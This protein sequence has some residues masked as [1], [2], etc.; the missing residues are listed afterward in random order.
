MKQISKIKNIESYRV[1]IYLLIALSFI[2]I[3]WRTYQ[4]D[5]SFSSL[6]PEKGYKIDYFFLV[7]S[8]KED[9]FVK[10]YVPQSTGRQKIFNERFDSPYF[11]IKYKNNST[12]K[13]A[14]WRSK[15]TDNSRFIKYSFTF[16][17]K[18]ASYKISP[19]IE[20][21]LVY[22]DEIYKYLE[23]ERY[24]EVDNI[25]I[26]SLAEVLKDN[27]KSVYKILRKIHNYVYNI[28]S[29][30]IS[31]LTTALEAYEN[32]LASCNG[33]SRLF[34][35]LC[36][37][38]NIPA[39]LVG[40]IIIEPGKKRT[41][42]QWLEVFIE[43]S[44]VPFDALNN[45]FAYIPDYYMELYKGDEFLITHTPNIDFDYHF[46]ISNK[47][48]IPATFT[49]DIMNH[50]R[51]G[52]F[53]FLL[54]QQYGI[55]W[56]FIRILFLLPLAGIVVA[57]FKNVVGLKSF[58]IFLPALISFSAI[59]IGFWNGMMLF[60]IVVGIVSLIHFPMEKLGLLHTPKLV[61]MLISVSISF[62]ALLFIQKISNQALFSGQLFIPI[63]ITT[64][65]AEKFAQSISEKGFI[66]SAYL[67]AQT[68]LIA[69]VCFIVVN[70][71]AMLA[72]LMT[73]PEF[74]LIEIC[75]MVLLGKW[76]GIRLT[77][78]SRFKW[79]VSY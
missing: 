15:D 54:N 64:I 49:G 50:S 1:S 69:G 22:N 32:N 30:P 59:P 63:V 9:V 61:I 53:Y 62:L 72:V 41:S 78:Y 19:D 71:D 76:I 2:S 33:K 57:L 77:E 6:I 55:S 39:R 27:E 56:D 45:H 44:W 43:G 29:A 28:P 23:A 70:S 10:A 11:T 31:D 35:A 79:V 75:I 37:A 13:R 52:E 74:I 66:E 16:S 25:D 12:G 18:S 47:T 34:V 38:N 3:S 48:S 46:V 42:H 20:V 14:I 4:E 67:L 17:G 40:G 21:P 65:T 73:Y 8:K 68:L 51:L 7:K 60:S 5:I 58:G 26:Q 36:R 24:I